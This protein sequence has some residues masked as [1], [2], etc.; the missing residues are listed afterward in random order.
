MVMTDCR[1]RTRPPASDSGWLATFRTMPPAIRVFLGYAF[2]VL[3]AIGVSL[4]TVVEQAVLVPISPLGVVVMGLLAYTIFAVT[5]T[6]QRKEAARTLDLGLS[7]LTVPAVPLLVLS[8]LPIEAA[9]VA[10]VA[11]VL[12]AG[13]TRPSTRAWLSE[14]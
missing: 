13:L 11:V 2:L 4:R 5:L 10:V 6:L 3:G 1:R 9:L 7:S 14:P 12:F 8:G